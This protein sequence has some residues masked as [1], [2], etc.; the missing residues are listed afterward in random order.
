MMLGAPF[1]GS[2]D[3]LSAVSAQ[4]EKRHHSTL[5]AN[6]PADKD[7][8]APSFILSAVSAQR[9]KRNHSTLKA[10]E[11][12]DKD[13]CAPS[14]IRLRLAESTADREFLSILRSSSINCMVTPYTYFYH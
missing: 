3:I 9:E 11:P 13:V 10:N 4:R 1:A 12:A 14:P 7:V 2:A 6:E 5:K 8:C